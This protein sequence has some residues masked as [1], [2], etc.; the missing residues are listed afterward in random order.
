MFLMFSMGIILTSS[1]CIYHAR[2]TVL[3]ILIVS[4]YPHDVLVSKLEGHGF[5]RWNT[6]WVRNWLNGRT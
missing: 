2:D 4:Q 5:D 6:C 1:F 3:S